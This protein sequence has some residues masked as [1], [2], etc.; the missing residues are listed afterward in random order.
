M[1]DI[2]LVEALSSLILLDAS[3]CDNNSAEGL[4]SLLTLPLPHLTRFPSLVSKLLQ[5]PLRF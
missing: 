5:F 1:D 2:S 4:L 3:R